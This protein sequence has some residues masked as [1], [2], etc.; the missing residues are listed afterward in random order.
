MRSLLALL[1]VATLGVTTLAQADVSA[2]SS[3]VRE[4]PPSAD[5][6]AAYMV[7]KNPDSSASVL[8]QVTSPDCKSVE[9]HQT[10]LQNGVAAM[11]AKDSL[12][13]PAHGH[14]KLSPGGYHLMLMGAAHPFKVGDSVSLVLHFKDG[15]TL[16]VTAPVLKD[17]PVHKAASAPAAE[18]KPN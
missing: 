1:P 2:T 5:V 7:L 3:W 12:T 8:Q 14:I 15:K 18:Q 6:L 4:A 11:S 13:I 9:I 17:A 16:A 10:S